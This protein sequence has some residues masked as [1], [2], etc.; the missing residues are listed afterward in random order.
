MAGINMKKA[1]RI[2]C[3]VCAAALLIASVPHQAYASTEV[4]E[5][6]RQKQEAIRKAEEDKKKLQSG[7]TDIKKIVADLQ[8]TKSDLEAYVTKLDANLTD[9][10]KKQSRCHACLPVFQE[11]RS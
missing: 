8:N 10:Q 2:I 3:M 4:E 1:K 7:L 11:I 9:V 5:S 6:I